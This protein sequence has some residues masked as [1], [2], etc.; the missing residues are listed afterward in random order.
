MRPGH[1]RLRKSGRAPEAKEGVLIYAALNPM[2][3]KV[4]SS[5][6][7]FNESHTDVQIEIRD[8]SD[9][10]GIQRLMT[11]LV[12]G[13]VPDIMEMQRIGTQTIRDRLFGYFFGQPLLLYYAPLDGVY[14]AGCPTGSWR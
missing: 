2:S 6:K 14:K 3:N 4:M 12:L 8:Y 7:R 13:R 10:N 5:I 1:H 11:E 9:E